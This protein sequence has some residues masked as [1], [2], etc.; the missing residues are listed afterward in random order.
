[1]AALLL[2]VGGPA[3]AQGSTRYV[4]TTGSDDSNCADA[5]F[6]CRTVQ[7]AVDQAAS[8][9][10]IKVAAGVYTGVQ[11]RPVPPGYINPPASGII[12]QVVYISKTVSI[13]GGY[14]AP[15]FVDPPDPE[16]NPSTLDAE[17]QGRVFCIA[18][19]ISP[20]V[21]GLRI[22]GGDATGLGGG[23]GSAGGGI[24]VHGPATA[25]LVNNVVAD[26]QVSGEGAGLYVLSSSPRL[27]HST[28]VRSTGGDGSGIYAT[29]AWWDD[30][31]SAVALSN[32]ILVS[33][34]VGISVTAGNTATLEATLWGTGTW[35]NESDWGGA[36]A[37][38]T[39]TANV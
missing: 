36:G 9:D 34:T 20:T 23:P 5:N 6:P 15:G 32:T 29:V 22:S 28:V 1:V 25:T 30:I 19:D 4:A 37:I 13:R 31:Y 35:A 18:G 26:N 3:R 2:V 21:E 12:T 8:D 17:D 24:Y 14:A 27:L 7:Y 11:G 33:H 38:M 39:G 16:A 10:V